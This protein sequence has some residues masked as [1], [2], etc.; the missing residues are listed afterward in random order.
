MTAF[1]GYQV[2][3]VHQDSEE[4]MDVMAKT[5]PDQVDLVT[6]DRLDLMDCLD[7]WEIRVYPV[8]TVVGEMMDSRDNLEDQ[9]FA[10]EHQVFLES[11]E[12]MGSLGFPVNRE[13]QDLELDPRECK[14]PLDSLDP[15]EN[16]ERWDSKAQMEMMEEMVGME[17]QED[18]EKRVF[19][20]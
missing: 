16:L 6:M 3:M 9:H 18:V 11:Q 20:A 10:M 7:F 17:F 5:T 12:L 19:P 15:K 14:E 8:L 4:S 2:K 13:N 1:Q